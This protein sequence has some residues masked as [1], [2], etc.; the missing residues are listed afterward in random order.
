[1]VDS[2]GRVQNF[3]GYVCA[4]VHLV[5]AL[6]FPVV[7]YRYESWTI[8]KTEHQRIDAFELEK[9][10]ES[11]LDSEEMEPVSTKENQP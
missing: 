9:I 8:K 3:P 2:E 11:P 4:Y 7:M 1:M 6:V 10:L 5:K